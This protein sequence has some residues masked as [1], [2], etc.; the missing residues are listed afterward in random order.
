MRVRNR[1]VNLNN[2]SRKGKYIYTYCNKV[3]RYTK[4]KKTK[5]NRRSVKKWDYWMVEPQVLI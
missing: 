2:K 3:G 5:K 1:I 4:Y